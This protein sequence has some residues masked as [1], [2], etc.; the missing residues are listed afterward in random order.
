MCVH[1]NYNTYFII[2]Y[3]NMSLIG[4]PIYQFKY[5]D[6]LNIWIKWNGVIYLPTQM[7]FIF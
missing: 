3:L 7:L 5:L 2:W 1:K 4:N 6:N